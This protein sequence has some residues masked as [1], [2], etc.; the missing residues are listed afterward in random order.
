M[1]RLNIVHITSCKLYI[2]KYLYAHGGASCPRSCPGLS[3]GKTKL[4]S[5][6]KVMPNRCRISL[7][8]TRPHWVYIEQEQGHG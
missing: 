1:A 2:L 6:T 4:K 3:G 8:P 5:D 7:T